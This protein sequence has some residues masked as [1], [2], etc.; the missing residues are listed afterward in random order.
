M[1]KT[2]CRTRVLGVKECKEYEIDLSQFPN[3]D[4]RGS[5]SGM[6][7][8]YYGEDALLVKCGKWIYYLGNL[9]NNIDAPIMT[10][11]ES[12]YFLLAH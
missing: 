5:I 3:F 4:A 6:K 10:R 12:I 9:G 8:L 2:R 11:G 7:K 1:G